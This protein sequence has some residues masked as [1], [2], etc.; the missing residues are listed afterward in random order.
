MPIHISAGF[1]A[2]L[3]VYELYW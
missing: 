1:A 3:G 2:R